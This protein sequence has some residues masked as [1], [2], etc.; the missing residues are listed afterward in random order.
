MR[1]TDDITVPTCPKIGEIYVVFIAT[2]NM[3]FLSGRKNTH[4]LKKWRKTE[5]WINSYKITK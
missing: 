2:R 5:F 1:W 4:V 3:I